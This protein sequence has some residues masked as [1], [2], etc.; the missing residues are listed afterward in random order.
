M[1]DIE[2]IIQVVLLHDAAASQE[3][4]PA[5]WATLQEA[6]LLYKAAERQVKFDRVY[7]AKTPPDFVNEQFLLPQATV[8]TAWEKLWSK[9]GQRRTFDTDILANRTRQLLGERGRGDA[10]VI[11]TDQEI[12]PPPQWRYMIWGGSANETVIST[13]P[14]DPRYWGIHMEESARVVTVKQRIRAACCSVVGGELG[15][16]RCQ[17]PRCFL[18]SSVDSVTTLDGMLYL[19]PE[20]ELP[21]L[22][23][24]GFVSLEESGSG[25]GNLLVNFAKKVGLVKSASAEDEQEPR[26]LGK[27]F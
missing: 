8:D 10:L 27:S 11:V 15:L 2:S 23:G 4:G 21:K 26:A 3:L 13:A 18:Y 22:S 5:L 12:T 1:R 6:E 17:N 16:E 24:L 9:S 14:T 25:S 7:V 19:G 20:H